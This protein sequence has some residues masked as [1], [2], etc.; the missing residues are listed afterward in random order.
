MK[1]VGLLAYGY[2]K[3]TRNPFSFSKVFMGEP[4]FSKIFFEEDS[5]NH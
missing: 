1:I 3:V 5:K 2:F 4:M